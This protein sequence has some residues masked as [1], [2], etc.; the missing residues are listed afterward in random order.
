M[1]PSFDSPAIAKNMHQAPGGECS[2]KEDLESRLSRSCQLSFGWNDKVDN[3]TV[4]ILEE[5]SLRLR[6]LQ[7]LRLL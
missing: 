1:C 6:K 2:L 5:L 7:K 4:F 3:Q